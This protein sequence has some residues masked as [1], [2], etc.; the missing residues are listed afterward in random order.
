MIQLN[1]GHC[2]DNGFRRQETLILSIIICKLKIDG[3]DSNLIFFQKQK[4]DLFN[5]L[6]S[7]THPLHKHKYTI[8]SI[9][10][11]LIII[12]ISGKIRM[13]IILDDIIF[14]NL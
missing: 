5:L 14:Y 8:S 10:F 13:N 4:L 6:V 2:I 7:L 3:I 11:N 12:I 9:K 1:V